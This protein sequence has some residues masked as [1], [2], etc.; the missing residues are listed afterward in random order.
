MGLVKYQQV[1]NEAWM[2]RAE[3]KKRC[4]KT[5]M[6][7]TTRKSFLTYESE[8]FGAE[9]MIWNLLALCRRPPSHLNLSPLSHEKPFCHDYVVAV[10]DNF[11]LL[12][13]E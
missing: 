8:S 11:A 6:K 10:R 12:I 4:M 13:T 7:L 3:K 5:K 2:G 9:N 1:T